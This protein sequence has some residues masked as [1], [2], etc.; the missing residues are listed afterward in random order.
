MEFHKL[1]DYARLLSVGDVVKAYKVTRDTVRRYCT[2][3]KIKECV[4]TR[5]G[6][7]IDPD[8]PAVIWE[9]RAVTTK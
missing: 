1:Q 5:N 9:P 3:G 4:M 8:A 7:L 6:Y 2:S